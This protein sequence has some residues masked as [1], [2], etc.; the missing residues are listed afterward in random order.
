[1]KEMRRS[2]VEVGER[3]SRMKGER[4]A[5]RRQQRGERA[6]GSP[7]TSL[8]SFFRRLLTEILVDRELL[9]VIVFATNAALSKADNQRALTH[10]VRD[11]AHSGWNRS[12]SLSQVAPPAFS[13]SVLL[14]TTL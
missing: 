12:P 6:A 10:G 2:R 8:L 13:F 1:M 5:G 4:L 7:S 9:E 3:R 14:P 11:E